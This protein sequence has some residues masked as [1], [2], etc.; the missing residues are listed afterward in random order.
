MIKLGNINIDDMNRIQ[1]VA[2]RVNSED[3]GIFTFSL[4]YRVAYKDGKI[5]EIEF[6]R[7]TN[8]FYTHYIAIHQEPWD[9]KHIETLSQCTLKMADDKEKGIKYCIAQKIIKEADP[10]EMTMD[11]IEAA[12][13]KRVKIVNKGDKK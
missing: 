10:V 4:K 12:L 6:P 8:P 11:E 7:V 5:E 3:D 13:G 2:I 1:L 9:D